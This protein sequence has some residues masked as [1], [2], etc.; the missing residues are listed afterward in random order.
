MMI[1]GKCGILRYKI[2]Y[3]W[4]SVGGGIWKLEGKQWEKKEIKLK[5]G[6]EVC[7]KFLKII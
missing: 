4:R 5:L 2:G 1:D 6:N 3:N 7:V